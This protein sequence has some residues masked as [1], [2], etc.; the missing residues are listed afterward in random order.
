MSP[1]RYQKRPRRPRP[2]KVPRTSI[3]IV[4]EG[5]KTEPIYFEAL[6]RLLSLTAVEVELASDCGSDPL[7]VVN[8]AIKL[9]DNRAAQ[10]KKLLKFSD[11]GSVW[12]IF[13]V[14]RISANPNFKRAVNKAQGNNICLALSN[15]CF[16]YWLHLH[17][18][19]IA[20]PEVKCVDVERNLKRVVPDYKKSD[21]NVLYR[22]AKNFDV[23]IIN[24]EALEK[25][26][27]WST[28]LWTHN[29]STNVHHLVRYLQ[30]QASL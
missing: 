28:K 24:A 4:C 11:Y 5:E 27:S 12:C 30:G 20:P 23:A 26:R 2:F 29:P 14:E 21:R 3:L 10:Y 1:R 15:V 25:S 7:S 17:F 18:E 9:K 22:I 13:D 6:R 19:A 8:H 16:E